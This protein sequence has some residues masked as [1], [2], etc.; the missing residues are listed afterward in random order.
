VHVVGMACTEGGGVV[1]AATPS[2]RGLSV[3]EWA[4]R[5]EIGPWA[6]LVCLHSSPLCT[7]TRASVHPP[8]RPLTLLCTIASLLVTT[9]SNAS[10]W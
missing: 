2:L 8:T 4:G 9:N 7:Y 5:G 10:V 3:G 1:E 6:N